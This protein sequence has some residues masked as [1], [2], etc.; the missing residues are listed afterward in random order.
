MSK[1]SKG[2]VEDVKYMK[3]NKLAVELLEKRKLTA[4]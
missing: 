4:T 3:A 2:F 1:L